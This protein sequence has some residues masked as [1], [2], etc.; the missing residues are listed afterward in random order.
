MLPRVVKDIFFEVGSEVTHLSTVCPAAHALFV[1]HILILRRDS[2][3]GNTEPLQNPTSEPSSDVA[4]PE[5]HLE[6]HVWS[7][8][9]A[10][11]GEYVGE[12]VM[13]MREKFHSARLDALQPTFP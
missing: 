12:V 6:A 13:C 11:V 10:K 4:S 9:V 8:C 2:I 5:A 3:D 7:S 1:S